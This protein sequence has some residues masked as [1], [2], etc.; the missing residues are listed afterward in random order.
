MKLQVS[1][2]FRRGTYG[3]IEEFANQV[4]IKTDGVA[5]YAALQEQVNI[6]KPLLTK[7]IN[8][9]AAASDGGKQLTQ[10]KLAAKKE[11]VD[12]LEVLALLTQI[13]AKGNEFYLLG[14]GFNS[15]KKPVNNR[16]K[17]LAKPEWKYL[18][19][20]VLS[21]TVEGEV[22]NFPS[23]TKE[24]GIQYS[25]DGWQT[26]HNGT[27]TSGKKFIVKG[28]DIKREV[29]LKLTFNGSFQRKSDASDAKGV[30]VL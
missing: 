8:A 11:L 14:A 27:Y 3:Q 5:E 23:G 17:P 26:A 2:G 16:N 25:Y 22:M 29:E 6:V 21:G 19:R 1:L 9:V 10:A 20:G 28:L 4:I 12:Q 13:N 7:F 30:F 15:R 18:R 24:I